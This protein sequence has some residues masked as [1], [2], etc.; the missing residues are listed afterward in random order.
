M[1]SLANADAAEALLNSLMELYNGVRPKNEEQ[2]SEGDDPNG[3]A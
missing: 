1:A 3:P 2:K